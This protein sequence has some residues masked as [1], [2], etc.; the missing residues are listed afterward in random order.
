MEVLD[1]DFRYT[2]GAGA[3][4]TGETITLQELHRG[5]RDAGKDIV[6]LAPTVSAV[7]ELRKVGFNDAMTIERL[8][9]DPSIQAEMRQKALIIDEAGMVSGRQMLELLQIAEQN[10]ARIV[11]SGDTQQIQSVEAC[12]ALRVLEK[13]SRFKSV[14]LREV[15]R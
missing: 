13:E 4:G 6:A 9:Q 1:R 3:A 10:S 8:L 2:Y 15:K 5:L 14:S 11:F 7:E 12:D